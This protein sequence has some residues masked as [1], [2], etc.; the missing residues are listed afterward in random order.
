MRIQGNVTTG[1]LS[2]S[3]KAGLLQNLKTGDVLQGTVKQLF[4]NHRAAIQMQGQQLVAQL[5]ASLSVG[6]KYFFQVDSIEGNTPELKVITEEQQSGQ[7]ITR[8][9]LQQLGIKESKLSVRLIKALVREQVPIQKNELLQALQYI[10]ENKISPQQAQPALM[11]LMK[12]RIPVTHASFQAVQAIQNDSIS[13][14]LASLERSLPSGQYPM[15]QAELEHVLRGFP[16]EQ[17]AVRAVFTADAQAAKPVLFPF[18][19]ELGLVSKVLNKQGWLNMLQQ[20]SP[21]ASQ[22][23][24][25]QTAFALPFTSSFEGAKEQLQSILG[26]QKQLITEAKVLQEALI[27]G[28]NTAAQSKE[29]LTM[30]FPRYFAK[31]APVTPEMEA[32]VRPLLEAL[33]EPKNYQA[34]ERLMH[35]WT[36][37]NESS[38]HHP[39]EQFLQRMLWT[40]RDAGLNAENA[41][42]SDAPHTTQFKHL[43]LEMLQNNGGG[44]GRENAQQLVH[45]LNGMQINNL[46]DN[47]Y[48]MQ[49]NIQI[50]SQKF[51]L[52]KDIDLHFEGKK[53]ADGNIDPEYCRIIFDLELHKMKETIV[54]LH[55]HKNALAI[56]I[57][58]DQDTT[59]ILVDKLRPDLQEALDKMNYQV[60][61]VICKPYTEGEK[62]HQAGNIDDGQAVQ[63]KV[64]FRI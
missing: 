29:N 18:L 33:I 11:Q 54:D 28:N 56:T 15:L 58:N 36:A 60:T 7:Q 2:R 25:S 41:L 35:I 3:S 37:S 12:M 23:L 4:P 38:I 22:D 9:L 50:P 51:G 8:Q 32:V 16:S 6:G 63:R 34:L 10:Q 47:S 48:V 45:L 14:S 62:Q 46:H 26:N 21:S 52:S 43:L 39:K 59:P 44:P 31:Q 17:S 19:Q 40:L 27:Q 53:T 42:K 64:D 24:S 20:W 61:S 57:Y 5:E 49:A 30:V 55:V 13:D 1:T